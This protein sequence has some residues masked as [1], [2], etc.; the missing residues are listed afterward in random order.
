M[1][2]RYHSHADPQ[3]RGRPRHAYRDARPDDRRLAEEI[4]A[5]LRARADD[6]DTA[7]WQ[8]IDSREGKGPPE[9]A[10]CALRH[11]VGHCEA[12]CWVPWRTPCNGPIAVVVDDAHDAVSKLAERMLGYLSEG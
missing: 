5:T 9:S 10:F 3:P 1:S 7:R 11:P 12:V 2:P 8:V 4:I 6:G